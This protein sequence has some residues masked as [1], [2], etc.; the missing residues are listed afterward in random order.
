MS[1]A[2]PGPS[3]T[4]S[5]NATAVVATN[6]GAV[7]ANA[8]VGYLTAAQVA[9]GGSNAALN[10]A[11]TALSDQTTGVDIAIAPLSQLAIFGVQVASG[12]GDATLT[13]PSGTG[14]RA[15][16]AAREVSRM[17]MLLTGGPT[18]PSPNIGEINL[19]AGMTYRASI[20]PTVGATPVPLTRGGLSTIAVRPDANLVATDASAVRI[21]AGTTFRARKYTRAPKPPTLGTPSTA[22]TGG[23]LPAGTY[24]FKATSLCQQAE[25]FPS[26]E[27]S[28]TTTGSTSTITVTWSGQHPK[29]DQI[30]IYM[31]SATNAETLLLAVP[32]ALGSYT[33]TA[34]A[35]ASSKEVPSSQ[36][37]SRVPFS[38][39][40]L[41]TSNDLHNFQA[42]SGDGADYTAVGAGTFPALGTGP[43]ASNGPSTLVV[44]DVQPGTKDP[45]ILYIGDSKTAGIG[46]AIAP[47]QAGGLYTMGW[48]SWSARGLKAMEAKLS[49]WIFGI[50]TAQLQ[51]LIDGTSWSG[52]RREM[53]QY[54]RVIYNALGHNDL[55]GGRT[56]LQLAGDH[57]KFARRC[58]TGTKYRLVT[59]TPSTITTDFGLTT[60]GQSTK[61]WE[62]ERVFFNTWIRNGCRVDA[63]GN[64]TTSLTGTTPSY[65][66][67]TNCYDAAAGV[68][69]NAQNVLTQ[70]GGFWMVPTAPDAS[71]VV[72]AATGLSGAVNANN[73]TITA[74]TNFPTSQPGM[75]SSGQSTKVLKMLTGAQAG[76]VAVIA[77]N[78]ASN[79]MATLYSSDLS[80]PSSYTGVA[81]APAIPFT[82]AP[83]AGDTFAIYSV[84]CADGVHETNFGY[85]TQYPLF[86]NN[87]LSPLYS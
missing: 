75:N 47:S 15:M 27:V 14:V 64:P 87:H 39:G 40:Q 3:V 31:G 33:I 59:L 49:A 17:A 37:T 11:G 76:A 8:S 55:A 83:S 65:I 20:E 56:G 50:A 81:G 34:P 4:V 43:V 22:T 48:G 25:S 66:D 35:L 2:N 86:V 45:C 72:S 51:Y 38:F 85:V 74:T 19:G 58:P 79:T 28:V 16:V 70:N 80:A 42:Y 26:A 69:V 7:P 63:S 23:T 71:Y 54:A 44:A 61:T 24:Y 60:T 29:D 41:L 13:S 68:E 77:H 10:A 9:A 57:L 12:T 62:S 52:N 32:A 30:G 67:A 21:P 36:T 5:P 84:Q 46:C 6:S 73:G 82:A 18:A 78:N 53:L 1:N